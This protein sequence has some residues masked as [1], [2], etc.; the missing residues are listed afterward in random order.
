MNDP[1]I[2]GDLVII[3][4]SMLKLGRIVKIALHLPSSVARA[5]KQ[6]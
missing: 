3:D 2:V 1:F 5:A 4:G 6:V